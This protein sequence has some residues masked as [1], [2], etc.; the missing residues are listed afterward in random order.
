LGIVVKLKLSVLEATEEETML[1][2]DF[3]MCSVPRVL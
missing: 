3:E 1:K 2:R